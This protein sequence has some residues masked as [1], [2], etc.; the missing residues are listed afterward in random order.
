M[1]GKGLLSRHDTGNEQGRIRK[2]NVIMDRLQEISNDYSV[3]SRM[4][5]IVSKKN[6][7]GVMEILRSKLNEL[8]GQYKQQLRIPPPK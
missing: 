6:K 2:E 8:Q 1:A 4:L 7:T 3:Y 5:R